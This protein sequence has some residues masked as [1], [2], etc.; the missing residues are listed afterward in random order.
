MKKKLKYSFNE[1][2]LVIK[3]ENSIYP[4]TV[5]IKWGR[6]SLSFQLKTNV[7]LF[8]CLTP[9]IHIFIDGIR[10]VYTMLFDFV[11]KNPLS[12]A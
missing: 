5:E 11:I 2:K 12:I 7:I 4:S 8:T 10:I 3:M 1:R 6:T 9:T